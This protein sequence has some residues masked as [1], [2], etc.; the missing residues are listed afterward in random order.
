MKTTPHFFLVLKLFCVVHIHEIAEILWIQLLTNLLLCRKKC[1]VVF[2]GWRNYNFFG[3]I[4]FF[5][6]ISYIFLGAKPHQKNHKNKIFSYNFLGAKH[7]Q[8]NIRKTY[9]LIIFFGSKTPPKNYK[10]KYFLIISFGSKTPPK[11][12][13]RKIYFYNFFWEQNLTKKNY[14]KKFLFL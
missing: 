10:K 14:K 4:I 5:Q 12:V 1:C 9:F 7:H 2:M 3:G 11:K 13:I 6:L 8:K